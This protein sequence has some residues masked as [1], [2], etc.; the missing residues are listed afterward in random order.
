MAVIEFVDRDVDAQ[1]ARTPARRHEGRR[2]W[3]KPPERV[4]GPVIRK[5]GPSG[6]PF[7]VLRLRRHG[8]AS[9]FSGAA[10]SSLYRT[11][12]ILQEPSRACDLDH[13]SARSHRCSACPG[14]VAPASARGA[15]RPR[16][17]QTRGADEDVLRAAGHRVAP[18]SSTSMHPRVEK[19][20]RNPLHGRSVLPP[21]LRRRDAA[22]RSERVQRSLGSG[23]IVDPAGFIVTNNHV[24]E[25]MT[26]VKVALA[27]KREFDG[28]DRAARSAHR[29]RRAQ[30]QGAAERFPDAR[31]RRFRQAARSATSCSPSAIRSASARRSRPAS[32]RR[33]LARRS[34]S[35]TTS[36]SSRPTRPSTPAIPA[37]RSST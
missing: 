30:D 8:R 31:A 7:F 16:C 2:R 18:A 24:I 6:R 11:V 21:L 22:S 5:G 19:Q 20:P 29:P 35:P 17:P 3:P 26:E 15:C 12:R 25:G 4:H 14:G 32:S 23:V 33:W 28:R 34:A 13:A 37:A 10:R 9:R 27:D 36:S 1:A